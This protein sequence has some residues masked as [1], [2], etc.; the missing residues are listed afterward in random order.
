M[1]RDRNVRRERH[2]VPHS[3]RRSVHQ[4]HLQHGHEG[5]HVVHLRRIRC[6]QDCQRQRSARGGGRLQRE[7]EGRRRNTV[8]TNGRPRAVNVET[9]SG[10]TFTIEKAA[11]GLRS[12]TGQS[13]VSKLLT[14]A[15]SEDRAVRQIGHIHYQRHY[16]TNQARCQYPWKKTL[17]NSAG[18][19]LSEAQADYGEQELTPY[20]VTI[21]VKERPDG[22]YVYSI[23]AE[24]EPPTR[25]TL[26]A[27]VNTHKGANGEL[28]VDEIVSQPDK[29][30]NTPGKKSLRGTE[31]DA[32]N[33]RHYC[34]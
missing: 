31:A 23:S 4:R 3:Q 16:T 15:V 14:R 26:H 12:R 2:P 22:D 1:K 7:R 25:R 9:E 11:Q 5:R 24:K 27:D 34:Q 18:E 13:T 32:E 6:G 20:T 28:F 33:K 19:E 17:R 21:N 29:K 8:T 10:E 30:V